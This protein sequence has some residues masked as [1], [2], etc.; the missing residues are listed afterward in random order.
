MHI[1][2]RSDIS[3]CAR[4]AHDGGPAVEGKATGMAAFF[5]PL[6]ALAAAGALLVLSFVVYEGYVLRAK[7]HRTGG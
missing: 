6:E 7:R 4:A 3:D 1:C 2:R 5:Y